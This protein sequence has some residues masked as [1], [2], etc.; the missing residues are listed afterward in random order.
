ME[1]KETNFRQYADLHETKWTT[2]YS[3]KNNK[4]NGCLQRSL[5]ES[6]DQYLEFSPYN[7]SYPALVHLVS[8]VVCSTVLK[9][10]VKDAL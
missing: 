10:V 3:F 6:V 1:D 7:I 2:F 5:R 9:S 4:T 8:T